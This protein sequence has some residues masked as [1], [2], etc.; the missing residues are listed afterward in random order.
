MTEAAPNTA[1]CATDKLKGVQTMIRQAGQRESVYE[2]NKRTKNYD[3][4][5]SILSKKQ[6]DLRIKIQDTKSTDQKCTLKTE[7]NKIIQNIR[8]RQISPNSEEIDLKA[9]TLQK[10]TTL[11]S[12]NKAPQPKDI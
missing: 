10:M 3:H 12:G 7:R 5:L 11:F 6:K 1:W 8:E 9:Q 4:E 2:K